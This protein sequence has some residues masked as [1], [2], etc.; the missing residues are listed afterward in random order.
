VLVDHALEGTW[1][2]P[3]RDRASLVGLLNL[4]LLPAVVV[5]EV[6]SVAD[7]PDMVLRGDAIFCGLGGLCPL[8]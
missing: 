6:S 7:L 2:W 3:G 5:E 1:P 4:L 8:L